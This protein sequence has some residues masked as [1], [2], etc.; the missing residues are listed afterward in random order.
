MS[1]DRSGGDTANYERIPDTIIAIGGGGKKVLYHY[2]QQEW[3]LETGLAPRS[4][5]QHPDFNAFVIDTAKG[6][7]Q[8]DEEIISRLRDRITEVAGNL[9]RGESNV[10]TKLEYVNP[11]EGT[12]SKFTSNVGLTA[13]RTVRSIASDASIRAWWLEDDEYMLVNQSDYDRGVVRRRALSKALYHAS[14]TGRNPLSEVVQNAT[15]DVALVTTFGGGTGSG[16]FIDIA[17]QLAKADAET[18]NL[19]GILPGQGEPNRRKANAAAAL[20]ELEYLAM[21]DKQAGGDLNPFDNIVLLP[22]GPARDLDDM[23]NFYDGVTYTIAA[24]ASLDPHDLDSFF[25]VSSSEDQPPAYAPFTVAY[26]Q[27]LRYPVGNVEDAEDDIDEFIDRKRSS[28]DEE[29]ELYDRLESFVVEELDGDASVALERA[30]ERNRDVDEPLDSEDARELKGRLDDLKLFV[31]QQQFDYVSHDPPL[32]WQQILEDQWEDAENATEG[33]ST[34]D[35]NAYFAVNIPKIA[36]R[37]DPIDEMYT[38]TADRRLERVIRDELAAV[39]R[40]ANLLKTAKLVADDALREGVEKALDDSTG[41]FTARSAPDRAVD[42]TAE[43]IRDLDE[44]LDYLEAFLEDARVEN[45][46]REH[47]ESWRD[48]VRDDVERLVEIDSNRKRVEELLEELEAELG[49]VAEQIEAANSKNGVD[50]NPIEFDAFDELNALLER[51]GEDPVDET[52]IRNTVSAAAKA[53]IAYIDAHEVGAL[54][55]FRGKHKEKK[56]QFGTHLDEVENDVFAITPAKKKNLL[57]RSFSCDFVGEGRFANW[58]GDLDDRRAE[59]SRNVVREFRRHLRNPRVDREAFE[60]VLEG[61]TDGTPPSFDEVSWPAGDVEAPL[62]DLE[63][64]LSQDASGTTARDLLSELCREGTEFDDPGL[65]RSAFRETAIGSV[66]RAAERLRAERDEQETRRRRYQ[67]LID[68]IEDLGGQFDVVVTGNDALEEDIDFEVGSDYTYVN[69]IKPANSTDSLRR[70][71][72]IEDAGLWETETGTINKQMETF[73][74]NVSR[75]GSR[76]TQLKE[77]ELERRGGGSGAVRYDGHFVAPVFLSRGLGTQQNPG[78]DDSVFGRVERIIRDGIALESGDDGTA[79]VS[80]GL[81]DEW[82]IG[83]VTFVGGVFL[84]NLQAMVNADQGYQAAYDDQLAELGRS[85]RVRHTHGL[86]GQDRK[87]LEYA[88]QYGETDDSDGDGD[89]DDEFES[90]SPVDPDSGAGPELDAD[91]GRSPAAGAGFVR[92]ADYIDVGSRDPNSDREE[93]IRKHGNDAEIR[94][95]L[96]KN[97]YVAFETFESTVNLD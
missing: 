34:A 89:G 67:Q 1:I 37:L 79:R 47:V 70:Y 9:G 54:G 84:D 16:M 56:K 49:R 27:I 78:S 93:F 51:I 63:S 61:E 32:D 7:Q 45:G 58:T 26:P 6:E 42:D 25:S 53:K 31:N 73:A 40:R 80:A 20:S 11:L 74:R 90:N 81:A 77:T 82:D 68:V 97:G 19:F 60:N 21:K 12:N 13:E 50:T 95:L 52:R 29:L 76:A 8:E 66:E 62:D 30:L 48:A 72:D 10:H 88:S 33:R 86:D 43:R 96:W 3:I 38:D 65:V 24:R 87:L 36:D 85:I 18:V 35:R 92:R 64:R 75:A 46:V 23:T 59:L 22:F 91:G 14:R 17:K 15:G 2:L 4:N 44:R 39:G 55:R 57:E 94:E 69:T 28:L 83:M 41:I 71:D 5:Q